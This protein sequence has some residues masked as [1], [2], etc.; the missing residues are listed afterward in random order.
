[1]ASLTL[2]LHPN[3]P[4]L[5]GKVTGAI[6]KLEQDRP[7]V[8]W[9]FI[10]SSQSLESEALSSVLQNMG[11]NHKISESVKELGIQIFQIKLHL[12][13]VLDVRTHF[14]ST[15]TFQYTHF[16]SCPL[17]SPPPTLSVKIG[18]IKG[19]A[20]RLSRTNSSKTSFEEMIK[21]FEKHL[22][23]RG[24]PESFIQNRL[25]EVNFED[26]KLAPQKSR[27]NKRILPFVTQCQPSVPNLKHTKFRNWK[28]HSDKALR[29]PGS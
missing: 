7:V 2:L 3:E 29:V 17:P 12:K 28:D 9:S 4:L 8:R 13:S 18:F 26:N 27:E 22:Q 14:K 24:Y 11:R 23:K 16:C 15:D 21:N 6:Y 5:L 1:M 20:S 10:I 19:E 25:S